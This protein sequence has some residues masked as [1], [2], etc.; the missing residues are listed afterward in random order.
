VQSTPGEAYLH[1]G[2]Q[3]TLGIAAGLG[4]G[5]GQELTVDVQLVGQAFEARGAIV[6]EPKPRK[7]TFADRISVSFPSKLL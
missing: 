2:A 3:G 4:L 6:V 5:A 1:V 7:G